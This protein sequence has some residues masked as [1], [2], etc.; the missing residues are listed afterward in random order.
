MEQDERDIVRFLERSATALERLADANERLNELAT[1]ERSDREREGELIAESSVVGTLACPS[2]GENDPYTRSQG[3]EG[4][5]SE[6]VLASPCGT[7]GAVM[8]A[9]PTGYR[10]TKSKDEAQKILAGEPL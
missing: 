7:C 4:R 2:C 6:F 3:G 1:E 5:L 10:I 8:Y 9:I